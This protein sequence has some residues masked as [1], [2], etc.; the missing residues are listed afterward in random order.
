MNECAELIS[1]DAFNARV[2][3]CMPWE[4]TMRH[5]RKQFTT[6]ARM[7]KWGEKDHTPQKDQVGMCLSGAENIQFSS[8]ACWHADAEVLWLKPKYKFKQVQSDAKWCELSN[9]AVAANVL[10]YGADRLVYTPQSGQIREVYT[11]CQWL[12]RGDVSFS[13]NGGL[14]TQYM[15]KKWL[16]KDLQFFDYRNERTQTPCP[17]T[18]SEAC[19]DNAFSFAAKE[20]VWVK[21]T[22]DMP[23]SLFELLTDQESDLQD[24]QAYGD[25]TYVTNVGARNVVLSVRRSDAQPFETWGGEMKIDD[26]RTASVA[27]TERPGYSC[28]GC[29]DP[30]QAAS[31][32]PVNVE[33][34]CGVPQRCDTCQ[35]WQ[36]VDVKAPQNNCGQPNR[37]CQECPAHHMSAGKDKNTQYE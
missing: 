25:K 6:F 29:Q 32:L 14:F 2:S 20:C 12:G 36:F 37:E 10:S 19:V 30:G 15:Q 9:T 28:L 16:S 22:K 24:I 11:Q 3:T 8:K 26:L 33:L 13:G 5:F 23:V 1:Q 7:W 35:A 4:S 34:S 18:V 31:P 17:D 27:V 21:K